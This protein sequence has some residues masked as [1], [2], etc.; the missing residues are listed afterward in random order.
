M[1]AH[2]ERSDVGKKAPSR[3]RWAQSRR[4]RTQRLVPRPLLEMLEERVVLSPTI[5][6]VNSTGIDTSGSGLVGTLPYVLSQ[7]NANTN[8]DGSDIEFDSSV[9]STPQTIAFET[10][11]I[12]SKLELSETAGPE[13]IEGPGAGLLTLTGGGF[14]ELLVV[15]DSVKASI[16]GMTLEPGSSEFS[17]TPVVNQPGGTVTLVDC[18]ITGATRYGVGNYG[19]ASLYGCTI[20]G[21]TV[22]VQNY[23]PRYYGSTA[24]LTL[25]DCGFYF[26]GEGVS[27]TGPVTLSGC[28]IN[29]NASPGSGRSGGLTST[30]PATLTD[31]T[32]SNNYAQIGGGLAISGVSTL[33]DCTI[34]GNSA[35]VGGGLAIGPATLTD[36]TISGNYAQTGGGVVVGGGSMLTDCTI[37]G[38]SASSQGGG[39]VLQG[40]PTIT[41]S[42]C[43]ISDNTAGSKGGGLYNSGT[44]TISDCTISG[45][46]AGTAGGGL[47]NLGFAYDLV[48][49][50]CTIA[51]NYAGSNGGGLY[52]AG[53]GTTLTAC[54][55]SGNSAGSECGGIYGA[56]GGTATLID[57]L[58]AYNRGY[59]ISGVGTSGSNDLIGTAAYYEVWPQNG[60]D[61]NIVGFEPDLGG[62]GDYGGPLQTVALL[63]GSPAIGAGT[64]V[65]GITT[66]ERGF[67]LD[68]PNPDIGAFQ[69]QPGLVVN[70]TVDGT[71]SPSGDLSLRQ[72]VNLAS[73]QAGDPADPTLN[74]TITFA[75][76]IAGDTI[77]L[78]SQLL[79]VR[80]RHNHYWPDHAERR[81][82][83]WKLMCWTS[84]VKTAS[85]I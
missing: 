36:C 17:S 68:S 8:T 80:Q 9:F 11:N 67:P 56:G 23:S 51:V 1:R 31:C 63:P 30:G 57:T 54:T 72:A 33:V 24:Y 21:N 66:D 78:D 38:N 28:T 83:G 69:V 73:A 84:E 14:G 13:V 42:G 47:Y 32:I 6:T 25:S 71:G 70:T 79:A 29:G 5:Y 49:T 77:S 16:S 20:S 59:D 4:G 48:L 85:R 46:S 22:G 75:S 82:G 50:N 65:S 74:S 34:S 18:A 10:T 60:V 53:P 52:N 61:G 44:A 15:N 58:V 7:A 45:N 3:F 26:N 35:Q 12:T 37:S 40:S 41:V 43:T 64:V 76:S 19:T 2:H 62:L 81:V 55:I 39:L 27:S